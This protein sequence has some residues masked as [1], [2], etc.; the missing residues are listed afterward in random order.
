MADKSSILEQQK[1]AGIR[2]EPEFSEERWTRFVDL[3]V[4]G[5]GR[6]NSPGGDYYDAFEAAF[7]LCCPP[8][9]K[10]REVMASVLK[11]DGEFKTFVKTFVE[12]EIK[13]R[14][15]MRTAGDEVGW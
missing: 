11:S 4:Y 14:E 3:L 5:G 2:S 12:T 9:R 1:L 7:N 10:L 8:H 13:R 15:M 6:G